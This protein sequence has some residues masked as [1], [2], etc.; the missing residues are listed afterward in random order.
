MKFQKKSLVEHPYEP[1][2]K[3]NPKKFLDTFPTEIP[4]T[5]LG[6]TV[7]DVSHGVQERMPDVISEKIFRPEDHHT[8]RNRKSNRIVIDGRH[9]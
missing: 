8:R 3:K 7:E 9:F 2:E 4:S 1:L 5:F 6:H